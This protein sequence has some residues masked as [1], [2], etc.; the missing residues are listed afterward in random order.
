M[1]A[2]SSNRAVADD[3]AQLEQ[4]ASD[5][6]GAPQPVL[7]GNGRD[8]LPHFGAETWPSS[9]YTGLP[10]PEEPS[11]LAMPAHDCVGR[12][13]RQVLTPASAEPSSQDPQQL[14]RG[15]KPS[16]WPSSRRAG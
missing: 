6:L 16:V 13:E 10:A 14:V 1:P 7:A 2:L 5:A 12:H 15:K 9:S 11:A 8:Q 4:F 3:D